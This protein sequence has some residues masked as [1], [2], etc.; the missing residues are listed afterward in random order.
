MLRPIAWDAPTDS[1]NAHALGGEHSCGVM[2]EIE[3][4]V[5]PQRRLVLFL[6]K[7]IEKR[8]IDSELG[9][10]KCGNEN[11]HIVFDAGFQDA[12]TLGVVREIFANR[13]IQLPTAKRLIGIPAF[14]NVVDDF[15]DG[16][17][18]DFGLERIVDAIVAGKKKLVVAD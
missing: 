18:I 1:E 11:R 3:I 9:I 6:A 17:E 16:V 8:E 15:F 5:K 14:E 7:A 13:A 10:R 2:L 12:A 4:G